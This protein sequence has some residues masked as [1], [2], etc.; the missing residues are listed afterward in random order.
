MKRNSRISK[1]P[2]AS[3]SKLR[4]S[5]WIAV[6]LGTA[7]GSAA[8]FA[9]LRSSSPTL[10]KME[11]SELATK[12][13]AATAF[14]PTVANAV[15]LLAA[16]PEEMV[17]IPGGEFSMG[18]IDPPAVD[19]VGMHAAADARP[20]HRVYVDG[21]WMDKT[22][23]T[24]EEFARFVKATGYVTVAERD[25]NRGRVSGCAAGESGRRFCRFLATGSSRT[26]KQPFPMVVVRQGSKLA[27]SGRAQEQPQRTRE[28]SSCPRGLPGC[29]GLRQVGRQAV[30]HGSGMGICSAWRS[31]WETLPMGR[32]IPA[33][34]QVDGKY[35]PGTL[36]GQ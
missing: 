30:A 32:R 3:Y 27:P 4:R 26:A 1:Q 25:A 33:K 11:A 2:A 23:V 14:G 18:A 29:F 5:V 35:S 34:R 28:V 15:P 8:A 21:F 17:W 31:R 12:G 6:L 22:D 13:A 16:P 7:I 20:I 19:Q 36:P 9:I 10:A 24:N